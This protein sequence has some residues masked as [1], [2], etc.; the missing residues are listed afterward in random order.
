MDK[1]R[2]TIQIIEILAGEPRVLGYH[3]LMVHDYG[4][5]QRFASLHVEMD[6]REDPLLC[7]EIIDNLERECHKRHG[8]H[9]VIHYDPVVTGDP[10]LERMRSLVQTLLQKQDSRIS[11]HDFR[12]VKGAGHTNLIFDI[13]LPG[14]LMGQAKAIKNRLDGDIAHEELGT[15]YTVVTFDLEAFNEG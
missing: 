3:D 8:V 4:P 1:K 7:H 12:M 13:V 5:G 2:I 15:Y 9:L 14:E 10:E 11:I 6:Q